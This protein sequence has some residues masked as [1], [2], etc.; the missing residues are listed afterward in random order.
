VSMPILNAAVT[1]D[2]SAGASG[3]A[4]AGAFK[5]RLDGVSCPT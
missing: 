1:L 2:S 4:T 3:F 5:G